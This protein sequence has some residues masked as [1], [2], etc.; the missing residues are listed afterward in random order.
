MSSALL[1]AAAITR[2]DLTVELRAREVFTTTFTFSALVL[3]IFNFALD[4][5]ADLAPVLSPGVLWVAIV[6]AGIL[7]LGRTFARE[8]DRGTLDALRASPVDRSTILFGKLFV[9]LTVL[10]AVELV[11]VPVF[12]ALFNVSPRWP[13]LVIIVLLGT[14]GFVTV[15][16]LLSAI[17]VQTR[18]REVMLPLLL[19][20]VVVPV[21]IASAKATA[22]ALAPVPSEGPPW[23][24][25][26]AAYDAIFLAVSVI[27]FDH[28]FE[29]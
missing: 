10:L 27:V 15:G 16:T 18:A 29:A 3:V 13:E 28:V 14:L 12:V 21:L 20:P 19:L 22:D 17:A 7:S 4:F 23:I 9:N 25:L 5:R 8:V 24:P 1:A 6:F 26:L 11:T 2:K